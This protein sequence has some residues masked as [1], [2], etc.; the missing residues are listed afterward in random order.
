MFKS[1]IAIATLGLAAIGTQRLDERPP[2]VFNEQSIRIEYAASMNEA[3]IQIDAESET[4]LER[5]E[6]RDPLGAQVLKLSAPEVPGRGIAGILIDTLET[7][8]K[9]VFDTYPEGV[10]DL[11]G[12]TMDGRVARGRVRL[13]HDL[14]QSPVV[15]YPAGGTVNVP[16]SFVARWLPDPEAIRYVVELEQ[17]DNDGLVVELPPGTS[18]FRVPPGV[19]A[20]NKDSHIE[21]GAVGA[22]GNITMVEVNFRTL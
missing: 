18:S 13:S 12:M 6:V 3:V 16:T 20:S 14:L 5:I 8:L 1:S 19:L 11:R 10:Y 2:I 7:T 17:D 21:V 22:N 4:Q 9:E 15:L